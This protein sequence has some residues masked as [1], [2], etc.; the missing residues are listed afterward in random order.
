LS[1]T[2]TV[3]A[4][5]AAFPLA[6]VTVHDTT[7]GPRPN[8]LPDGGTHTIVAPGQLS[9]AVAENVTCASQRPG[10]VTAAVSAGQITSGRSKSLTVT[11]NVQRFV[12]PLASVPTHVTTVWPT[13]KWLP[14]AGEQTTV[15]PAQLSFALAVKVTT[16]S[17]RPNW[18]FVTTFCGQLTTG[19]S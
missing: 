18:L 7:V 14:D 19:T 5:A 8:R 6:S 9:S 15:V 1:F 2:V 10:S 17:Q 16:A 12:F 4:H 3:K 13:T 11:E